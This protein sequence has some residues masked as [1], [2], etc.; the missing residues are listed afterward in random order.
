MPIFV[1]S[2]LMPFEKMGLNVFEVSL[3]AASLVVVAAS[4]VEANFHSRV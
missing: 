4:A 2:L 3:H 1:M